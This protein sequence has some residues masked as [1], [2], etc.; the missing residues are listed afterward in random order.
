MQLR[1]PRVP[2]AVDRRERELREF[3]P[4]AGEDMPRALKELGDLRAVPY[5]EIVALC[6]Y[7]S[8][9]SPFETKHGVKGAEFENVIV[10]VGRGWNLYNFNGDAR[11]GNG[12]S[13][14][15]RQQTRRLRAQSEPLLCHL[16]EAEEAFGRSCSPNSF[17][18]QPCRR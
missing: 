7:L 3:D 8:G 5:Q 14:G 9:H 18:L 6:R 10:V 15:S 1:R 17:P 16:F 2:D 11:I 13:P 4:E 12:R